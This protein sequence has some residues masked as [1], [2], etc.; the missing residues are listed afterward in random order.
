MVTGGWY[1][2]FLSSTELYDYSQGT[3]GSWREAGPLPSGRWG[4]RGASVAGSLHVLGGQDNKYKDQILAWDPV[5]QTWARA[6]KLYTGRSWHGV[7]EVTL[8]SI[9]HYCTLHI[10]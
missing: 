10:S 4:V 8:D 1:S 3:Q 6:G 2:G 9:S 7:T 5:T